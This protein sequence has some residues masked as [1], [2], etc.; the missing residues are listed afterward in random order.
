M[1]NKTKSYLCVPVTFCLLVIREQRRACVG[2]SLGCAR[3]PGATVCGVELEN[4]RDKECKL[5]ICGVFL[6]SR[7]PKSLCPNGEFPDLS[8]TTSPGTR[9]DS[10]TCHESR[11]ETCL[12]PRRWYVAVTLVRAEWSCQR[13]CQMCVLRAPPG[14][15]FCPSEWEIPDC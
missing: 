1:A 7:P 2:G 15:V 9:E 14:Q 10:H 4:R 3:Q 11:V 13:V 8:R 6:K 5:S 12:W